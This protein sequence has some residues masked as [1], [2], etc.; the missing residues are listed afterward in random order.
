MSSKRK[1]EELVE[2][3]T[4]VL[5]YLQDHGLND[6][7]KTFAKEAKLKGASTEKALNLDTLFDNFVKK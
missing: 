5:K 6:T 4:T 3:N 7:A 2:I 1:A